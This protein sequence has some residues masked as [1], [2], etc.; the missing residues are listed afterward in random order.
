M[1]YEVLNK[2]RS[3]FYSIVLFT[4]LIL[5]TWEIFIYRITIIPLSLLFSIIFGIGTLSTIFDFNNY[6]NTY[7]LKNWK[8]YLF[9]F[10]QNIVSWGF[11]ACSVLVL[12]NYYFS[13]GELTEKKY[14]IV[15]RF[16]LTGSK[17][18]RNARKPLVI[19][20]YEGK[21]KE[22]VFSP[23]YFEELNDF[24]FVTITT[25]EGFIYWDIIVNQKLEK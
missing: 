18:N 14:K 8:L 11:I 22:L 21:M 9:A 10:I 5:I 3:T 7:S 2:K 12:S 13:R 15:E 17:G 4:G 20:N 6:K 24:N 1:N 23:R 16:S 25:Q 19:V